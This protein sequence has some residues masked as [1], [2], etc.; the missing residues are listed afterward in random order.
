MF[1]VVL[2]SFRRLIFC[3][4]RFVCFCCSAAAAAVCVF[5]SVFLF[6]VVQVVLCFVRVLPRCFVLFSCVV[7][8]CD[9]SCRVF[10][11]V[12][13]FVFRFFLPL[14]NLVL[15]LERATTVLFISILRI[16]IPFEASWG[17]LTV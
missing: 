1:C 6:L 17:K 9:A 4:T 3:C 2:I 7:S 8:R 13:C 14:S 16:V 11:S 12:S 10:L 5:L 15:C